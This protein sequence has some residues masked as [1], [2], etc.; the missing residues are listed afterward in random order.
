[1]AVE[2]QSK[3]VMSTDEAAGS[4]LDLNLSLNLNNSPPTLSHDQ[5]HQSVELNLLA[6]VVVTPDREVV[7]LTKPTNSGDL[8]DGDGSDNSSTVT[9]KR[10]HPDPD[11]ENAEILKKKLRLSWEQSIVLE[12]TFKTTTTP[13]SKLKEA[14]ADQLG[15]KVRQ[16]EVWFQNRRARTKLKNTE[17]EHEY[18]KQNC[19]SLMERVRRLQKEVEE[20][21]ALKLPPPP[22]CMQI[23][24]ATTLTL[25]PSCERVGIPTAVIDPVNAG[26]VG[27]DLSLGLA[28]PNS[29]NPWDSVGQMKRRLF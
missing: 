17:A 29:G 20:L 18:M 2:T 14:L 7:D 11:G 5:Q 16:V 3:I 13:T 8:E 19:V 22:L 6:P 4:G 25:C 27:V 12:E 21:R 1:M 26:R 24:P 28:G 15:I 10:T 9:R 23:P